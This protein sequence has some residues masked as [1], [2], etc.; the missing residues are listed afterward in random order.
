M[1]MMQGHSYDSWLSAQARSGSFYRWS[2]LLCTLPA[3]IFLFL[4][5][6]SVALVANL[7]LRNGAT[8]DEVGN[9]AMFRGLQ[10]FG[11]GLIFR[12]QEFLLGQ[13]WAPWT[14]LFRVDVLNVIGVSI[15][16][17]GLICR[18]S[19]TRA[20]AAWMSVGAMAV[21][22][23]ISPMMWTTWRPRWLPWFLESYIDG[24]HI[25]GKPQPWLFPIFPWV[26]FGFAGLTAGF[27]LFSK[28]TEENPEKALGAFGVAGVW[29][30]LASL[31]L[32]SR[33]VQLYSVDD[34]WHTSPNFFFARLGIL[35]ILLF[36]AFAWCRWGAGEW[37][38]SPFS[39]LGQTS[40]LVYWVHL[41]FVYGRFSILAHNSA[42]IPT[43]TVGLIII[44]ISMIL[45]SLARTKYKG[46]G[47]EVLAWIKRFPR[48]ASES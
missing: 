30:L 14:D 44:F 17:L 24:V 46:K 27:L 19:K 32:D 39:Q 12:I 22:A 48:L 35:L 11:A 41:E 25:Y 38:F 10:I 33:P 42:T 37:G 34:Y 8:F 4:A 3:P 21:V 15:V 9:A 29:M 43:A 26:A 16:M 18:F 23:L 45:L 1:L 6:V 36:F 7:K 2:Q 40:L 5:G 13:P 20:A 47:T 31:W 28:W